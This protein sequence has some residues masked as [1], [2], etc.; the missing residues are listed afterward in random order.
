MPN[1][2]NFSNSNIPTNFMPQSNTEQ[3]VG[4]QSKTKQIEKSMDNLS[5][6]RPVD[7]MAAAIQSECSNLFQNITRTKADL[8]NLDTRDLMS[9]DGLR[10]IKQIKTE[11]EKV[12]IEQKKLSEF[13]E[14]HN[15]KVNNK[16]FEEAI[17]AH[18]KNLNINPENISSEASKFINDMNDKGLLKKW[19]NGKFVP[20]TAKEV[21]DLIDL[22]VKYIQ[23]T[24]Q[25][26]S[27][28]DKE[29]QTKKNQDDNHELKDSTTQNFPKDNTKIKE[30]SKSALINFDKKNKYEQQIFV[31][32]LMMQAIIQE[33]MRARKEKLKEEAHRVHELK[34]EQHDLVLEDTKRTINKEEETNRTMKIEQLAKDEISKTRDLMI[35]LLTFIIASGNFE[36]VQIVVGLP[37]KAYPIE[38]FTQKVSEP[39]IHKVTVLNI[40]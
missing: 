5:P 15:Y 27:K 20:L 36:F 24:Y 31:L 38:G 28:S 12:T 2:V 9:S 4:N 21:K 32:Y 1:N 25:L 30:T 39:S 7:L 22:T 34:I 26:N 18:F 17:L 33:R 6:N 19:E 14:L 37:F 3:S 8:T 35:P 16:P 40:G 13:G 11:E 29:N 23:Y 10:K